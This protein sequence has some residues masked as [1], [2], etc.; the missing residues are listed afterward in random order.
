VLWRWP[1]QRLVPDRHSSHSVIAASRPPGPIPN[2]R[3]ETYLSLAPAPSL[4]RRGGRRLYSQQDVTIRKIL[5]SRR[6]MPL[7]QKSSH[8]SPHAVLIRQKVLTSARKMSSPATKVSCSAERCHRPRKRFHFPPEDVTVCQKV[9]TS[10]RKMS[11]SAKKVLTSSRK[12]SSPAKK[13]SLLAES[14]H[15][16]PKRFHF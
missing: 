12:M 16:S 1:V 14:C 9:L 8:F 15:R 2:C 7:L 5:T 3:T 4:S 6:Q 13:F 10:S 11:P